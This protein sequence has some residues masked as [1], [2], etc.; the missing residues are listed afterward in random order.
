MVAF[1]LNCD[2]QVIIDIL[3][4]VVIN[5]F[6]LLES[7]AIFVAEWIRCQVNNRHV[8]LILSEKSWLFSVNQPNSNMMTIAL[9]PTASWYLPE[10]YL[11][12]KDWRN[13]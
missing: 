10:L 8:F 4:A 12:K 1:L 9:I 6:R 13:I 3:I 2:Y 11:L 5:M 7:A